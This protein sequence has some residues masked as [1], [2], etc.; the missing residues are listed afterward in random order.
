M[1][2]SLLQ[3]SEIIV[4]LMVIQCVRMNMKAL[5][6]SPRL[7]MSLI[8]D[9]WVLLA[10]IGDIHSPLANNPLALGTPCSVDESG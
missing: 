4:R 5:Y 7:Q 9:N 1:T 8:L 3:S 10:I 2:W 6:L